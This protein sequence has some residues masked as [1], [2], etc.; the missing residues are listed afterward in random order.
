MSKPK[1]VFKLPWKRDQDGVYQ[2]S[3]PL[4]QALG[5]FEKVMKLAADACGDAGIPGLNAGLSSVAE[6]L[7][8][9]QVRLLNH[10][11]IAIH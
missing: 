6:G 3:E 11:R 5:V 4:V 1:R 10:I 9:L 8:R 2:L 7:R